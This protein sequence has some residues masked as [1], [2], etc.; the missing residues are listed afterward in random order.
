MVRMSC[1]HWREIEWQ[2]YI[3]KI[4]KINIFNL[5][6]LIFIWKTDSPESE[7][8]TTQSDVYTTFWK[9]AKKIEKLFILI[10]F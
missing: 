5:I 7:E 1:E 10:Y 8:T 6:L 9:T 2:T 3:I 4:I